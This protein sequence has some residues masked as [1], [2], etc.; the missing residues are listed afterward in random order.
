MQRLKN[1]NVNIKNKVQRP[2]IIVVDAKVVVDASFSNKKRKEEN[3]DGLI[4]STMK[5]YTKM[6][7]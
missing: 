5:F 1:S 3:K 2:K 7:R 6:D 4:M